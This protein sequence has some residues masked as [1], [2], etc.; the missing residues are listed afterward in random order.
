MNPLLTIA[1]AATSRAKLS[2]LASLLGGLPVRFV[3]HEELTTAVLSLRQDGDTIADNAIHRASAVAASC[4]FLV[5]ADASGLEVDALA[6]R[7]GVRSA[8]YAHGMAT[9][10]ENNAALLRDMDEFSPGDRSARFR[11]VLA[12]AGPGLDAPIVVEGVCEGA[13]AR[14]AGGAPGTGYEPLFC[15][16][17]AGGR[18]MSELTSEERLE[19]S[20]T[21]R[22]ARALRPKL[23]AHLDALVDEVEQI[24]R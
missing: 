10:A 1:V 13:V 12:V 11:C 21:A 5:L 14:G 2:E 6:G 9:D 22:A 3:S 8:T 20:H 24:L 16:D 17:A 19:H 15:V 7:P 4:H 18:H 23:V